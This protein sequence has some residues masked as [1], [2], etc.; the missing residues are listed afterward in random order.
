MFTVE[1][2][3]RTNAKGNEYSA[4]VVYYNNGEEKQI[5]KMIFLSALE[6][7]LYKQLNSIKK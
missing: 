1:L 3:T 4:L 7:S 6:L 2:E 5:Y